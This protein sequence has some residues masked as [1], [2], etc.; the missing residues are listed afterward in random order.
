MEVNQAH[1]ISLRGYA[2][3]LR[4]NANFRRLW[5]GQIVSGTGDWFYSVAIY[6]LLFRLTGSAKPVAIAVVL[7]IL[8]MFLAGPT[9]G[10]V[11]D[12]LSR[13]K[14]MIATDLFRAAVVLGMLFIRSA[15]Q[16]WILYVL[17]AIEISTAAFFEA[18]RNAVIPNVV[19]R[20]RIATA[21]GLSSTTWS[22]TVTLGAA[23]GGLTV[24]YLGREAVFLLNS[25]S[26]LA[27][28]L[29]ISRMHF[30]EQHVQ[31]HLK[32]ELSEV[33]GAGPVLEGFR[34][35][36][37]D[38][39]LA[40]LLTLKFGLGILGARVVLVSIIGSTELQIAG[41]PAL[42][43]TALFMFQGIGSILGPLLSGPIVRN[44]PARMR[45][46]VLVGYLMAGVSYIVFGGSRGLPAAAICMIVAHCGGSF[47]WVYSTTM[48]HLNT[49][50]R[51]R[52]RVF[53]ADLAL[54]MV[55][56][57]AA[58][59]ACGW[60]IDQGTPARDAAAGIG[61]ALFLPAAAWALGIRRLWRG[62]R[63]AK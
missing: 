36:A 43:M 58:T 13:R 7:Q 28:A 11:N 44:Q 45:W 24:T 46:A 9:A 59:Y 1:A 52:G 54:F 8:P 23:I 41:Q 25:I 35:V 12:R 4:E 40:S 55:T 42:G 60:M 14:V 57:S 37:R 31:K 19:P 2:S 61:L 39:R 16:I 32:L 33:L 26:F 21:N 62:E 48:L 18:G 20:E 22:V 10:A 51:F 34:Y 5:L 3:L 38:L 56:A 15:D 29:L 50:D 49:E 27:S 47:V 17:L 53:A 30:H 6:D 63:P